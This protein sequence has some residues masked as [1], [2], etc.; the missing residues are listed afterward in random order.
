MR[1][2]ADPEPRRRRDVAA[3]RRRPTGP[4]RRSPT[5]RSRRRRSTPG[6][7]ST[8]ARL[9]AGERI[10]P[11]DSS[12]RSARDVERAAVVG[13]ERVEQRPR[14]RVADD[15][16][17][18]RLL[19]FDELP[20]RERVEVVLGR[21]DDRAAREQR[22]ERHPVRGAVHERAR[23]HAARARL[24]APLGDLL[25]RRDRRAA[26]ARAAHRAEEH[27]FVA[28]H[29]ALRHARSCRR[30]RGCRGR[31]PSGARSRASGDAAASA[32]S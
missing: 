21:D 32:V 19:A 4:G 27:V 18:V 22:A 7:R 9:S 29:H 11:P 3:R 25:G 6:S 10:A 8:S 26:A 12:T 30:C 14:E 31:R 15:H 5:R 2:V 17:E 1:V 13:V 28:P 16:D 20:Q 24:A 23:G